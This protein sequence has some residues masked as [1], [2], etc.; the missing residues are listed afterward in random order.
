MNRPVK[1]SRVKLKQTAIKYSA[2]FP[3]QKS[4]SL[5]L[6]SGNG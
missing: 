1:Y 5:H 4:G 2:D 6:N 3:T